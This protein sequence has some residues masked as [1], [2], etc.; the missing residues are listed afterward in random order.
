MKKLLQNLL[1]G[2][3][4]FVAPVVFSQTNLPINEFVRTYQATPNAQLLDVRTPAEWR[5][6]KVTAATCVDYTSADFKQGIAKLD[7]TKP[8][9]VYCAVGGRSIK[10]AKVLQDA[11]FKQVYNLTGAGFTQLH[12]RG[13]K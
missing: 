4:L 10:A 9:F 3:L 5:Q 6:G 13:L 12:E 11:G 1:F 7:K 2:M 8:V